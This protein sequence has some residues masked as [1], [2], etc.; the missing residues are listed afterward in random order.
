MFAV[1]ATRRQQDDSLQKEERDE[2]ERLY[3]RIFSKLPVYA[4]EHACVK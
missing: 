1:A 4:L 3:K 2:R